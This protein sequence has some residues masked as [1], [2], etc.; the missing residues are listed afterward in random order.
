MKGLSGSNSVVEC[1][2]AKVEVAGSNP[3]SRSRFYADLL[4]G[5]FWTV[6]VLVPVRAGTPPR[7]PPELDVLFSTNVQALALLAFVAACFIISP[8]AAPSSAPAITASPLKGGLFVGLVLSLQAIVVTY[9]GW[10]GAIYFMEEDKNPAANLP[11]SSISAVL[12]CIAIFLLV[13]LALFHIMPLKQ[14]SA[15]QMPVADAATALFGFRGRQLVLVI[16]LITA[17]S[18]INATL[19]VTPRIL[20][21]MAR[22]GFMPKWVTPVNRGGTPTVA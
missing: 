2:L 21:A 3:V 18:T 9:D 15:S 14:I 20:F 11:R 22:D 4:I 7:I 5:D 17:V 10:Y 6:P 13:N 12:A 16:S 8:G 1:D 19:L